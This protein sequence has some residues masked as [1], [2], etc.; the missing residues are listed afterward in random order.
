MTEPD[1]RPVRSRSA[2]TRSASTWRRARR[3][4]KSSSEARESGILHQCQDP[5]YPDEC[6]R[7]RQ[8]GRRAADNVAERTEAADLIR[9]EEHTSEIQS[10]MRISYAVFCL[11]KKSRNTY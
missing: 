2:A 11:N 6:V 7:H 8:D 9:S 5:E 3:F 1:S 4:Q 10:L